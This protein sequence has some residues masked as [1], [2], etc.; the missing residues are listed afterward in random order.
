MIF[1]MMHDKKNPG[2]F[3]YIQSN[4]AQLL[5]AF[6]PSPQHCSPV[7]RL[8]WQ[9]LIFYGVKRAQYLLLRTQIHQHTN[10]QIHKYKRTITNA[11][12]LSLYFMEWKAHSASFQRKLLAKALSCSFFQV[13]FQR[14]LNVLLQPPIIRIIIPSS[15]RLCLNTS[16]ATTKKQF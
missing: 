11:Q 16:G 3:F 5:N 2:T 1:E 10:T 8:R 6:F 7:C 4:F 14:V 13:G 12:L 15:P 9:V